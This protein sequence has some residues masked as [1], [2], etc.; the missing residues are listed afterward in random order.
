MHAP[1]NAKWPFIGNG[2]LGGRRLA[3]SKP[4]YLVYLR[5]QRFAELGH[6]DL[7][8]PR[9]T[10]RNTNIQRDPTIQVLAHDGLAAETKLVS[11]PL[12]RKR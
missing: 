8:D 2:W 11:S 7:E 3:R 12:L 9:E 5:L 10:N 4:G 6:L 1:R